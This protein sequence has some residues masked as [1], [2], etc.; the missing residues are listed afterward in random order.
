MNSTKL[1][2]I[3]GRTLKQGSGVSL[4]KDTADYQ[5]AVNTLQMNKEDMANLGLQ[6]G[7]AVQVKAYGSEVE[8]NCKGA[9]L[10]EGM[11]FLAYGPASS[12]LLDIETDGSG[13][14]VSKGFEVEVARVS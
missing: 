8:L 2:F 12:K 1:I 10:P 13:M 5:T 7:D 9:N 6:D 3:S 11:V 4:G 14:P